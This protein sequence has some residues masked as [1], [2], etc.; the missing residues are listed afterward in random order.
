MKINVG[1]TERA[2][3]IIIGVVILGLGLYFQNWWGLVGLIPLVTGSI[4]FCPLYRLLGINS[5][6]R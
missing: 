3:R 1:Q 4:R 2:L 5:C 6:K